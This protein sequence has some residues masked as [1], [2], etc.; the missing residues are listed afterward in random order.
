MTAEHSYKGWANYTVEDNNVL[1]T[2]EGWEHRLSRNKEEKRPEEEPRTTDMP[3]VKPSM[4]EIPVSTSF[5]CGFLP[6]GSQLQVSQSPLRE[7]GKGSKVASSY[8]LASGS[9]VW[10]VCTKWDGY[11]SHLDVFL[12]RRAGVDL[13]DMLGLRW[14]FLYRPKQP[15][16]VG[17]WTTSF[18]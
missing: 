8:C 14:T 15:D 18:I 1:T 4:L 7:L 2:L 10:R 3:W 13:G 17:P 9:K 6:N 5:N 11:R 12:W 16:A